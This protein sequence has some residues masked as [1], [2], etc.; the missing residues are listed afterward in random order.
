M[1]EWEQGFLGFVEFVGFVGLAGRSQKISR[2]EG[3]IYILSI[4]IFIRR[5]NRSNFQI[6]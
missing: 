1:I 4:S 6:W 5:L 2:T 3:R